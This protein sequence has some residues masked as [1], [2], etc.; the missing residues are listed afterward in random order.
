[1]AEGASERKPFLAGGAACETCGAAFGATGTKVCTTAVTGAVEAE[2]LLAVNAD[3]KI[4][5]AAKPSIIRLT[6]GSV[7]HP[8]RRAASSAPV[9]VAV[10]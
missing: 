4:D 9:M 10:R 8:E 2:P 7:T 5:A 6:T 3:A 1:V